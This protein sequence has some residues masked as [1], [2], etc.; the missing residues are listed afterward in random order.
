MTTRPM[1][2]SQLSWY[3]YEHEIILRLYINQLTSLTLLAVQIA[4]FDLAVSLWIDH[5][6]AN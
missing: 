2:M 1:K 6:H 5:V 3:W 4:Q